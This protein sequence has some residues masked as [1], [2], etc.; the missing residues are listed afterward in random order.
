METMCDTSKKT[1]QV[2]RQKKTKNKK[3]PLKLILKT[4]GLDKI[5]WREKK[6]EKSK[7]TDSQNFETDCD[8]W[9]NVIQSTILMI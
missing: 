3:L 7:L 9:S 2:I 6:K 4:Y 8:F 5:T 1:S